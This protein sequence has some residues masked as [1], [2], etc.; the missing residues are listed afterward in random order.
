MI[1]MVDFSKYG[2]SAAVFFFVVILL[3]AIQSQLETELLILE[4][5]FQRGGW[6]EIAVI[7]SYGGFLVYKMK[8]PNKSPFW[9]QTSWM[10]FSVVFFSQL[11]LGVSG[12]ERFLMTGDLHLPVPALIISGPIY[13]GEVSIMTFLF[14]ST[15]ILTGPA[16]CSHLC[17]FGGMDNAVAGRKAGKSSWLRKSGI[18]HT[19]LVLIILITLLLRIFHVGGLYALAGGLVAG[20]IG[21][22]L[23]VFVSGRKGKMANCVLFCPVGTIVSYLKYV[24]PFRM[25]LDESC[26]ACGMCSFACNYD[27]LT[28]NDIRKGKPGL[29]CTYCGD[30]LAA[31]QHDSIKYKFLNMDTG[32]ARNLYLFLTVSFH[33][34]FLALARI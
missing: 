34:I 30:C 6:I 15:I 12:L 11:I 31:C 14:L 9:R 25:Y 19:F 20:L 22:A 26:T 13:R 10:I 7:A 32:T 2:L 21:I 16:W 4:R 18:K 23:I 17:Y 1:K 33:V 3:T 29:T 5:F 24:N 27:A 8:D 28:K